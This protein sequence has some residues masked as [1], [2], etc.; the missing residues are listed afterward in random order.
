M[1]LRIAC[2]LLILL[3]G[4]TKKP[5]STSVRV[6]DGHCPKDNSLPRRY[7]LHGELRDDNDK[8]VTWASMTHLTC[9]GEQLMVWIYGPQNDIQFDSHDGPLTK[10][11]CGKSIVCNYDCSDYINQREKECAKLK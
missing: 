6:E 10:E 2:L 7:T 9:P 5:E 1:K 4:C 11:E 8:P 3:T